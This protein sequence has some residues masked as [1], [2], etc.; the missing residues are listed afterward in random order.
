MEVSTKF[1]GSRLQG[2]WKVWESFKVHPRV[3]LV[4]KQGYCLP[5]KEKPPLTRFPTIKSSYSAP[6]KQKALLEAVQQMVQKRAVVPVQNKNSLGFYSRLFLVPKPE[7]K[8]RPVID[9]SVVNTFLHVPTFKMETAEV[10][11]ASLQAG[12]WVA[13]IDLTDAYFHVP[14]HQKFQKYLR[15]HV[16]G[17]A[18]QFRAL[19]FGIATAPLEFTRVVKEVKLWLWFTRGSNPSVFGRLAGE[20]QRSGFLCSG[21]SKI[22]QSSRKVGLDCQFEKIR[23]QSNS[24]SR[25]SGL[26]VQPSRRFG[27]PKSKEIG[28]AQ[29]FGS[30]HFARSQHYSKEAHVTNWGHGFHGE[31]SSFG[32]DPYETVSVVSEDQLAVSP[33]IGQGGPNFSVDKGPSGLVDGSSKLTQGFESASERT[34]HSD[35][36]RC[37]RE[38][39]GGSLE[40]WYCKWVLAAIR[41]RLPYQYFGTESSETFSRTIK[42]KNSVGFFKQLNCGLLYQQGRRHSLLRNVCFDVENSGLVQCQGDPDQGQTYSRESQCDSRFPVQE[43]QG[44]SDGVVFA[45]SGLSRNLP[46]LAQANGG[47][48]CHQLECQASN[49]RISCPRRQGLADRCIEH[50]LGGSGRLCFLSSSHPSSVSSENDHLQVQSHCDSTRVAEDALVL[51]SGGIVSQGSTEASS[52]V[53]SPEATLQSQIPQESG[54]SE[55][56]CLVSGLL[57]EGQGGFSVEVADRIKAP[58]RES[59]RRVYDSRWAIFQKWAQENQVNVTKPTIPQIADFLNHLFTDRNLKPRTIAGYRT[60]VADGLGSAGQMVSQSLDLNRLIASFHRDRPSANRS[61]PNWDLSLVLL[62]LTRAPFEPLGKADLKILTFKTVFL[63]ALASGK[64]RSEI[65]AWTFDSFSRKRDWSEVTFS[66]STA[67]IAKNQLASEGPLAIQPV[68]IPALKPTL[69]PSLI[70]DKSLCPVRA[71]RYYLDKTKDLRKGKKLL[72]VAIKEGYSKDISKATIS[73]WIILAYQKSDQEVQNVSQVKAHEVRALAASLA[74]KG[75][76][77]LDEIMASCFL[78]SHSTFTNFYLKDLCWHNGDVMKIGPVVAAQHVV[79]C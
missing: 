75:G 19:S 76:V 39:L 4:L 30:F 59:S 69:D 77:A 72:F 24:G 8:W 9:L 34:Q 23:T 25:V 3:V 37:I 6:V 66:P 29:N 35:V 41:K 13:S 68:V 32:S 64:R 18:Y 42:A 28:Q 44:H 48:V 78:R 11:R 1:P 55:P 60:S 61:I 20:G 12:E 73:S 56:P 50:L 27:L 70:Q 65:H 26:S 57:Q 62:A 43:G 58:Q 22:D 21:C 2:Y 49:L 54:V 17:Q 79:N 7:N 47:S 53:Q 16:Q 45:S 51:G 46:S 10:I 67:F 40:Q 31:N 63:L 33:V 15:F 5:F 52:S 36:H 71:F 38:G 14:I 74:F